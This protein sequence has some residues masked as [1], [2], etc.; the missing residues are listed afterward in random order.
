MV[1]VINEEIAYTPLADTWEKKKPLQESLTTLLK[2]L[3]D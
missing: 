1:G 2:Y 3:A